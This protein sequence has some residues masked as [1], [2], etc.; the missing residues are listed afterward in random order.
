[1]FSD[2]SEAC[3]FSQGAFQNWG[4]VDKCPTTT[5][6]YF[7][8][9]W[10]PTG[11]AIDPV[12]LDLATWFSAQ[13]YGGTLTSSQVTTAL[14]YTPANCTAGTTGSD[15]LTLSSGLVPAANLP[16]ATPSV[17]GAV[18]QIAPTTF[19]TSTGS[20][21]ANTCNSTVQVA[22]A[23][24]TTAMT[25]VITPSADTS[26][27]TGWGSTGGLILDV[28]PTA[29]YANIKICNQTAAT[30]SSPGAVTFNITAR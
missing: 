21:S 24:V 27:A 7:V 17:A 28:W 23:S 19:T 11:S 2:P 22:M 25:F 3:R 4:R 26:G 14:T 13:T 20:V 29:G 18:I 1:M 16:A 12:A 6:H 9:S 10:H 15:C 30:I 8:Y 5:G